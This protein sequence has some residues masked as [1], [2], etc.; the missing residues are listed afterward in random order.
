MINGIK[1]MINEKKE[2]TE[3]ADLLL[4]ETS[5]IG[6]LDDSIVLGEAADDESEE[7][8]DQEEEKKE[9]P[10]TAAEENNDEE[11]SEEELKEVEDIED[12]PIEDQPAGAGNDENDILNAPID[13]SDE[14]PMNI[15]GDDLPTPVGKQTGE[16]IEDTDIL[17]TEIDLGSNTMKDVL[18]VPPGNAP[19]AVNDDVLNQRIDDGFGGDEPGPS[20]EENPE[21]PLGSPTEPIPEPEQKPA[22]ESGSDPEEPLGDDPEFESTLFAGLENLDEST[23]KTIMDRL[24][25]KD[26]GDDCKDGKDCKKK[27]EDHKDSDGDGKCD[28]CDEKMVEGYITMSDDDEPFTEEILMSGDEKPD[29]KPAETGA[30]DTASA[31]EPTEEPAAED[32]PV[33]AAVKDKVAETESPL[34]A[35]TPE[36]DIKDTLMKKLASMTKSMEDVKLQ[37]SKLAQ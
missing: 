19:E 1:A 37:V 28:K 5:L 35:E 15:P 23:K 9:E 8:L 21:N 7:K 22:E 29:E 31:E 17:S 14:T 20:T 16:P 33:T 10:E 34:E 13:G 32:S 6:K 36:G 27:C 12:A 18:P 2:F 30:E 26:C 25:K 24:K 11:G 4:E 3:A